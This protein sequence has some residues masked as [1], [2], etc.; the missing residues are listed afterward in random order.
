MDFWK[1]I[2]YPHLYPRFA[3]DTPVF[4]RHFQ[5]VPKIGGTQYIKGNRRVSSNIVTDF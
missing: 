4:E 1:A 3:F 5:R 2:S